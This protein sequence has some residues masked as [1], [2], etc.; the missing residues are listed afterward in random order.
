MRFTNLRFY[1]AKNI[2]RFFPLVIAHIPATRL[3]PWSCGQQNSRDVIRSSI[4][5]SKIKVNTRDEYGYFFSLLGYYDWKLWAVAKAVCQKGD[6]IIEVGANIGTETIGYADIVG[7]KG[8]VI[9]FEPVPE[10]LTRL[11]ESIK[12]SLL[13][14]IL[15]EP[16]A[17]S[18]SIGTI[19]FVFPEGS[20]SG[21]GHIDYGDDFRP[22]RKFTVDT[23]TLDTYLINKNIRLLMMD[24]EGA[25]SMVLRGGVNVIDTTHPVI[26]VEAHHNKKEM[27]DFFVNHG[28]TV[29]SIERLGLRKPQ[30]DPNVAQYNW[31]AI[32]DSE[33]KLS[34]KVDRCIKLAGLLP[35]IK[36]LH[37]LNQS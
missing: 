21:I 37:P 15:V 18:D 34:A 16:I 20:N 6:T 35:P 12:I 29:Y 36:Y 23:T 4:T 25:E 9:S 30:I 13:K 28:Y 11:K 19:D 1:F 17:L 10:N 5:G 2:A 22:G 24:V 33:P 8:Q 7:K 3:Y 31:V 14:N 32:H 26:I 27:F